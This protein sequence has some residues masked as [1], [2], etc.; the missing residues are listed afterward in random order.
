MKRKIILLLFL[1][2]NVFLFAQKTYNISFDKKSFA[3]NMDGNVLS[4]APLDYNYFFLSDTLSPALPYFTY[5]ILRPENTVINNFEITIRKE[6]IFNNVSINSNPKGMPVSLMDISS[7]NPIS[8][9]RVSALTPVSFIGNDILKGYSFATFNITPFIYDATLR[10]LYFISEISIT[11]KE[12]GISS[13]KQFRNKSGRSEILQM[14]I[15][16]NE[17][18]SMYSES[19]T[20][21][22]SITSNN[23]VEYLVV[24]TEALK[25]S[26]TPLVNW[27]NQKG[28]RAKVIT[29]ESIY[30]TY[31]GSNNQLKIKNCLYDYYSNRGLKWVLLGGDNTIV[32]AQ[33]CY[34]HASRYTDSNAPTDLFYACFDKAFNWDANANGIIGETDDDID[35]YPEIY[36]SRLPVRTGNHVTSYVN[37]LLTYEKQP[38]SS[39]YIKSM[40]LT[41]TKLWNIWDGQSDAHRRNE[42]M[43]EQ[44]I[45]PNWNG[46]K[47]Y[48]YDTGSSMAGNANYDLTVDNL[49]TQI[50]KGYHFLHMATHGGIDAWA[51][52]KGSNYHSSNA[53]AQTNADATIIITMACSTN[54]FDSSTDPCLSEAFIRNSKSCLAYLGSSRYGWGYSIETS[55]LGPSFKYNALF[56]KNLFSGEPSVEPYKWGAA[57][58][59]AKQQMAGSS[60]SYNPERWVQFQLN[61]MGDPEMNI[62]T[63]TPSTFSNVTVLQNGTSV[64]IDTGGISG[65]KIALCS[66]DDYGESFFSVAEDVSSH[67]FTNVDVPCSICIMKHNYIPYFFNQDVYIQNKTLRGKNVFVGK[68][69]KMGRNVTP[70][71]SQGDVTVSEGAEV[72]VDAEGNVLLDSGFKCDKGGTL[73][74]IK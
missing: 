28:V 23:T 30:N 24:T 14:V 53:T 74:I 33:G 29:L 39:G 32:P 15:N 16:P 10:E 6:R 60:G 45:A 43:Y 5:N 73:K 58:A 52:E 55:D 11:L 57:V 68:N 2:T 47:S 62:Y 1:T 36:V 18:S 65:C 56:F 27:K 26:F 7:N 3:F 37:K 69:I 49:Q 46:N 71:I 41:G 35:L 44:Y 59:L 20:E 64:T 70:N 67:T 48:L 34:I 38:H 17:I 63:E 4:I 22:P 42:V 21:E 31:S 50:N 40:L 8:I 72:V 66:K 25:E 61:P 9:A 13:I 51:M 54:G 19:T 12:E